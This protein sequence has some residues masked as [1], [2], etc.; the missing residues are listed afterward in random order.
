MNFYI[1]ATLATIT[2]LGVA[3]F[4][5]R[6]DKRPAPWPLL[7]LAVITLPFSAL[8]NPLI[9]KPAFNAL[10][11]TTEFSSSTHAWP[12]WFVLIA[13]LIAPIVEES[14]KILPM[15]VG[16]LF[17]HFDPRTAYRSGFA[18]GYGFGL[19]EMWYLAYQLTVSKPDFATGSFLPLVGFF[20]ERTA[21]AI[22]HACL[23]AIAALGFG[24]AGSVRYLL[25]AISLHYL[26]NIGAG[27]HKS[28]YLSTELTGVIVGAAI[29]VLFRVAIRVEGNLETEPPPFVT[30]PA[31]P[32][33]VTPGPKP[34]NSTQY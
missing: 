3:T 12:I 10:L 9:K 15:G 23:S 16:S 30:R 34:S 1:W 25:L 22:G 2:S 32:E 4:W 33:S 17:R 27:L 19:G 24:G 28:G 21:V 8:V 7:R 14:I 31:M 26:L 20:G 6:R 18:L 11:Q 5:L 13:V 29:L